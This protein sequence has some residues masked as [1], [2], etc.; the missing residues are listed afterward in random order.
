M[1]EGTD[2]R[3]DQEEELPTRGLSIVF[4]VARDRLSLQM[5]QIGRLDT[6][7]A[8]L[9]GFGSAVASVAAAFLA[10]G[11]QDLG[12][13]VRGL[14]I[15]SLFIYVFLLIVSLFAVFQ[16][17]FEYGPDLYDLRNRLGPNTQ[18]SA[19]QHLVVYSLTEA[20]EEN[21]PKIIMKSDAATVQIVLLSIQ[22]I[23]LIAAAS[24]STISSAGA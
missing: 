10:L 22:A 16:R 1:G 24:I 7:L 17:R 3:P 9:F 5:G 18:V 19:F 15:F 4:K 23:S 8:S 11:S 6:K 21:K 20:Y 13:P 14:L 2:D 12:L